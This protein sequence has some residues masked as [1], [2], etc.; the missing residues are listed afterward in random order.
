MIQDIELIDGDFKFSSTEFG[1]MLKYYY[2]RFG[3][4][5]FTLPD[6]ELY[7]TDGERPSVVNQA[8]IHFI[9]TPHHYD[10]ST[11][12]WVID[13]SAY[14]HRKYGPALIRPTYMEWYFN[15]INVTKHVY[16]ICKYHGYDPMNIPKEEMDILYIVYGLGV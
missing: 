16:T 13:G 12:E 10:S 3:N 6:S 1:K 11:D 15:G 2:E 7:T 14:Y 4:T 8:G 5:P 9:L